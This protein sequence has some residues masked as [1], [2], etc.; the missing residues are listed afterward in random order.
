MG[1]GKGRG[2]KSPPKV[3]VSIHTGFVGRSKAGREPPSPSV[4]GACQWRGLRLRRRRC[5]RCR[6][7]ITRVSSRRRRPR[8]FGPWTRRTRRDGRVRTFA[9]PLCSLVMCQGCLPES[10][11]AD[12]RTRDLFSRKSNAL[13]TTPPGHTR[14]LYSCSSLP[15]VKLWRMSVQILR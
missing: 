4:C 9:P 15:T 13:T 5:N 10:G 7:L 8:M 3:R 12:I 6:L 2:R 1:S 11:T 14:V